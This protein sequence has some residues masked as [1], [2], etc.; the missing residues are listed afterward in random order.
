MRVRSLLLTIPL[1]A[2]LAGCG[3]D[4]G[5]N[6]EG[7]AITTTVVDLSEASFT[8]LT[9]TDAAEVDALDNTFRAEYVEV[10]AGTPITF[11]NDGMNVHNVIPAAEGEF[12]P[13]EA[14]AFEPGAETTI[15]FEQ[16]GDYAYYCSLHGT[17][18]KGMTG[19]VR[20]VEP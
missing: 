14:D 1:A 8:D 20:V 9:D 4:P 10:S 5:I 13:V 3:S 15:T 11:R 12:A 16:P 19:A 7:S 6:A 17:V 18:D 2:V